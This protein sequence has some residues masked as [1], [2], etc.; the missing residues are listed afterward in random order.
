MRVIIQRVKSSQVEVNGEIVG[1]IGRGLNL[2]VGIADTDTEAEL[3]WMARKCLELRLFPD[4]ASD[5]GRWDKSV[6]DIGGELL[7]VSQF[8]LYGDCRSCRRPSFHRS[9][10][11]EAAEKLY[12]KFVKKLR[13]SGL[14][15]ETGSF[16]AMM[17]VSI[18]ND[19][20]VTLVLERESA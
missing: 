12:E 11:P 9:A 18:D 2:L 13:H 20:P 16:G 14:K 15:V 4:S 3:D 8:T 1:K 6:Q 5:G 17:Q 19:G 10:A 7:V